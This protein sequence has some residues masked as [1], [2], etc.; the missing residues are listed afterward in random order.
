MHVVKSDGKMTFAELAESNV[1]VFFYFNLFDRNTLCLD[2][3]LCTI[4]NET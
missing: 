1:P 3:Q 2:K 4:N